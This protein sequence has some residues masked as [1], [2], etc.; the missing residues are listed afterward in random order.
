[1]AAVYER[2]MVEEIRAYIGSP[3]Q[4]KS[5]ALED[6]ARRYAEACRA[7]NER[8]A[9]CADFLAK[10]LR[11]QALQLAETEPDLLELVATLGFPEFAAW[12]ELSATYGLE[13]LSP[14]R[15]DVAKALSEAY[16]LERKLDPLIRQHRRL[17]I[18]Q[19]P[20]KD[21]LPIMRQIAAIDVMAPYWRTD[22]AEFERH[23]ANELLG[24]ARAVRH[25]AEPGDLRQMIEE[26]EAEHWQ[27]EVP[28]ELALEYAG[29]ARYL[30]E[31]ST[32]PELAGQI[33]AALQRR[34]VPRLE[35]LRQRWIDATRKLRKQDP[36][37]LPPLSLMGMVTPAFAFLDQQIENQRYSAFQGDI[38]ALQKAMR[39][40]AAADQVS[41]LLA[42][43]ES[44]GYPMPPIT[45]AEV[46]EFKLSAKEAKM[47]S[48]GV[49]VAL[50][51]GGIA[52]LVFGFFML[53]EYLL[54][55]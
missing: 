38:Q 29:L 54:K 8:L 9:R 43:S 11:T 3:D 10:G 33:V 6:L 20:V 47:L 7:A 42:K 24:L 1:M 27:G 44:H 13:R 46:A 19:A 49:I 4:T 28:R 23:R 48:V 37:W 39:S 36:A 40:D 12:Q 31:R 16:E 22:V 34:E 5:P 17:S 14:L 26:F 52:A 2:R 55:S 51:F 45:Q 41:I 32:F 53:R 35:E 25:S 18:A 15:S 50:V 30:H 21:R